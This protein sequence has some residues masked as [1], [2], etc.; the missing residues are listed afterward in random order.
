MKFFLIEDNK[1]LRKNILIIMNY[2]FGNDIIIFLLKIND[3]H[4]EKIKQRKKYIK[5]IQVQCFY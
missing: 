3:N 5:S 2:H 1:F 4:W